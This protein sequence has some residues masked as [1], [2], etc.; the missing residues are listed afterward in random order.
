MTM[1]RRHALALLAVLALSGPAFA[2]ETPQSV[3]I[4]WLKG[5]N[6]ITLAKARGTLEKSLGE[7]GIKVEWAGPFPAS[8]PAV[9]ALNAGAI[10][11]TVGS[12]TS[13]V[14]SLAGNAPAV[15]FAYQR[16]GPD[17]EAIIVKKNADIHGIKDLIGRSV[18]V[19]RGGTGEYLLVRALEKNGIDPAAVKR[20]YLGPSDAGPAFATDHVDAWAIWD[21]FLTIALNT[22]DARVLAN[23]PAIGSENAIVMIAHSG[24][25]QKYRSTLK[26]VY[27]AL[28][29]DNA[30]SVANPEAAG[31]IWAT[32]LKTPESYAKSLGVNNAVPTIPAGPAQAQQ[33]DH[34]ADWYVSNGIIP[35]KPDITDGVVDIL[36]P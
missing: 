16:M 26:L 25:A 22:F 4:G 11:I 2:E 21:P 30:W 31:T 20:V 19:N 24:F 1:T 10:D 3:R 12:S 35:K 9:E 34:I 6:D 15:V 17:A 5:T 13:F 29:A 36:K 8:A 14:T 33:I 23:G 32:E 28:A 7:H 18:A 27:Q